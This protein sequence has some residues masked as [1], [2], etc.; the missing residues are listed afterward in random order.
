M[1]ITTAQFIFRGNFSTLSDDDI[2]S[3]ITVISAQW[4]G[5]QEFWADAITTVRDSKR[6]LILNLLTA[7]YLA[8]FYGETLEGVAAN[9]GMP[10]QMKSMSGVDLKF[11]P[12]K[13]QEAMYALLTNTYG[14]RAM[15]MIH[16][17]PERF[18]L[19]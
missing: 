1:A 3:A 12:I 2:A 17:A 9:G 6:D 19:Y 5:T 14:I 10:L 11:L 4:A 15:Q 7:W 13:T 18:K 8:D 16:S